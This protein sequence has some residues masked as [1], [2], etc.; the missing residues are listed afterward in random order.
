METRANRVQYHEGQRLRASELFG[1]QDYLVELERRHNTELHSS[2]IIL[3]LDARSS[4]RGT[5]DRQPGVAIQRD[6]RMLVLEEPRDVAAATTSQCIDSWLVYCEKPRRT[7]RPGISPCGPCEFDR[8]LEFVELIDTLVDAN[9]QPVAPVEG[10]IYLG[11]TRC[12]SKREIP[13]AF[14]SSAGIKGPRGDMVMLVGPE[15]GRDRAGF[16]LIAT[17][18]SNPRIAIDRA[19]VN[20][21]NGTVTLSSYRHCARV[22]LP[23]NQLLVAQAREPGQ[24]GQKMHIRLQPDIQGNVRSVRIDFFAGREKLGDGIVIREGENVGDIVKALPQDRILVKLEG[25]LPPVA[26]VEV[27]ATADGPAT[28]SSFFDTD[29]DISLHSCGGSL[30]LDGS[31][32]AK[33]TSTAPL[34]GCL[35]VFPSDD[36]EREPNGLSFTAM[37]STPKGP[38][39]PGFYSVETGDAAQPKQEVRLDLGEKR[40]ND[41]TVRFSV[42]RETPQA[43]EE[44]L[45]MT[46]ICGVTIPIPDAVTIDPAKPP[47]SVRV[48]GNIK[49]APIKP[50][51]SDPIFTALLVQAWLAGLQGSVQ[52]SRRW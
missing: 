16:K 2:G 31:P 20:H 6:G 38:P 52:A 40:D 26:P 39:L 13:Y 19:G 43:F 47:V 51:P 12:E 3:G 44:W 50:D 33:Q 24:A 9:D 37:S 7:H 29:A 4:W 11:R 21:L 45:H 46:G 10:A 36:P 15:T 30:Y 25:G 42:G 22:L 35:P 49:R 28:P 14:L 1:E 34:R 5:L 18:E 48:S 27:A 41:Q 23:N 32:Q 8:L 17:G